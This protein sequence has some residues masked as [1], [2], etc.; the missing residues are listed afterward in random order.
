MTKPSPKP[1]TPLDYT[2][3][4]YHPELGETYYGDQEAL[5]EE[6]KQAMRDRMAHARS[7]RKH[8]TKDLNPLFH[9]AWRMMVD[10][11]LTS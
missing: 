3:H 6:R 9:L 2:G 5:T 8:R 4:P 7:L 1:V 10:T 11:L